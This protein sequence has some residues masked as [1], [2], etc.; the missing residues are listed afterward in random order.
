MIELIYLFSQYRWRNRMISTVVLLVELFQNVGFI[1][2]EVF[3]FFFVL[4]K[5]GV[6]NIIT[7]R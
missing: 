6:S 3:C 1:D 7:I 4:L 2:N 5:K